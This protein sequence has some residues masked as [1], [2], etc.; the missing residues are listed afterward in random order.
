M[1]LQSATARPAND[2]T[3]ALNASDTSFTVGSGNYKGLTVNLAP[4]K[5]AS[6]L[7]SGDDGVSIALNTVTT[8]TGAAQFTNH[9]LTS[10]ASCAA[11]ID[12]TSH[13][14]ATSAVTAINAAIST[15]ST[16][17]AIL[18]AT[19]NR[20]GHKISNLN[21]T[22]ENLT[23]AESRIR[24]VDMA[25]MMTDYTKYNILVQA[26]TAMLAQA[27]MSGQGVLQLLK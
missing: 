25:K 16:E 19:Q 14:A 7:T 21:T 24:D 15:V 17:R 9:V 13:S 1:R 27:N 5:T 18:G 6:D 26:A 4:G 11:G 23:A 3:I 12:V 22:F 8:A 10:D 20:L 2:Q